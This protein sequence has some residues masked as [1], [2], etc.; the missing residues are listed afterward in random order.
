MDELGR[1]VKSPMNSAK[2]VHEG[3]VGLAEAGGFPCNWV[4][5]GASV[6]LG[7]GVRVGSGVGI[8]AGVGEVKADKSRIRTTTGVGC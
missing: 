4:M 6:G 7:F 8:G 1:T 5:V 2:F 3:V